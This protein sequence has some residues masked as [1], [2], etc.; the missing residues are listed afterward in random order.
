MPPPEPG[1][2]LGKRTSNLMNGDEKLHCRSEDHL[3][4]R[5]AEIGD[6]AAVKAHIRED[7]ELV[8]KKGEYRYTPLCL[9]AKKHPQVVEFLLES[10][11]DVA[12]H[13]NSGFAPLHFAASKG[14]MECVEILLKAGADVNKPNSG[15]YTPLILAVHHG[16]GLVAKRLIDAG[17]DC[18]AKTMMNL[19]ALK[20]VQTTCREKKYDFQGV[21]I[22]AILE[23]R[24]PDS[25]CPPWNVDY[26]ELAR[27]QREYEEE[28]N[29]RERV[30]LKAMEQAKQ[31][32]ASVAG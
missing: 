30:R 11:A 9:A 17:A 15:G 13:D 22:G 21:K 8:N 6:L 1:P 2:W 23:T 14:N 5:D 24:A 26:K 7:P 12:M 27:K 3:V 18:A 32:N 10:G 31:Q 29:K 16:W 20:L 4:L 28:F 19:T 25:G